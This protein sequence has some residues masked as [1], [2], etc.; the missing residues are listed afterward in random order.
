ME[1]KYKS[2]WGK[3]RN[4]VYYVV[5]VINDVSYWMVDYNEHLKQNINKKYWRR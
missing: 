3:D 1:Y 5:L 4:D 2:F